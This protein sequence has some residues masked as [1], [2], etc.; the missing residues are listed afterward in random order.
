MITDYRRF[1]R[2]KTIVAFALL[3]SI[4]FISLTLSCV[5]GVSGVKGVDAERAYNIQ[6]LDTPPK[7]IHRVQAKYPFEAKT[8]RIEGRVVVNF[9][10]TKE[11]T[12]KEASVFQS[13]PEGVFDQA[14]L[15]AVKQWKFDPGK[16][17][18]EPVETR[19]RTPFVFKLSPAPT[20]PNS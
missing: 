15:E 1:S 2:K 16:I 8:Q 14:A 4:C 6:E 19:V 10:V 20:V 18:G 3:I 17:G 11:G 13:S 7:P 5:S 9:L 12:V